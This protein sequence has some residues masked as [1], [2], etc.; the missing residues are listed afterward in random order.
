M[1]R[2]SQSRSWMSNSDESYVPIL[3][4]GEVVGFCNPHYVTRIVDTLNEDEISRKALQAACADLIARAGRTDIGVHDLMQQYL[5]LAS[6][7]KHGVAAIALYLKERQAELD[8]NDEEFAKFCDS[9][10]LSKKELNAI[11]NG[12]LV[13]PKQLTPVSRILGMS[14]DDVIVVL[15]GD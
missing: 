11:Y 3:H 5:E 8:L 9:F 14:V 13:D 10:R 2:F 12:E 4:E 6:R 15:R 1:V 7:P